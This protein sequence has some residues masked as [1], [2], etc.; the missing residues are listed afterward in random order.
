MGGVQWTPVGCRGCAC[1]L[2]ATVTPF[3]LCHTCL[4]TCLSCSSSL[5]SCP[6][7]EQD[8]PSSCCSAPALGPWLW[9]AQRPRDAV[10]HGLV[11]MRTWL[12]A[13]AHPCFGAAVPAK[14]AG[15]TAARG[16]CFSHPAPSRTCASQHPIWGGSAFRAGKADSCSQQAPWW[17]SPS[18]NLQQTHPLP[19]RCSLQPTERCCQ[20]VAVPISSYPAESLDSSF[21]TCHKE[22]AGNLLRCGHHCCKSLWCGCCFLSHQVCNRRVFGCDLIPV[23]PL[24]IL[25][26]HTILSE[27][28]KNLLWTKKAPDV[29]I[30]LA[31]FSCSRTKGFSLN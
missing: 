28:Q 11:W 31:Q 22:G 2:G 29:A 3:P 21:L 19:S 15:Q 9:W 27:T 4:W 1:W 20:D 25:S 24:E 5:L 14:G 6:V 17:A 7:S 30:A 10:T 12:T 26:V 23:A 13:G 8:L 16:A 18:S